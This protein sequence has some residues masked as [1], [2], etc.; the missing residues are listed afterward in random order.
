VGD[1]FFLKLAYRGDKRSIERELRSYRKIADAA[2]GE[3]V[4]ISRLHGIVQDEAGLVLGLL[5][6]YIDARAKNLA[7]AVR[8]NVP[9][10]LRQK[11]AV[12]VKSAVERLHTAGIIWGD[13][14]TENVLIDSDNDA[15][16]VDFDG[17]Y[18]EGWVD[19]ELAGTVAGD[20]QGMAKIMSALGV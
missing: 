7:C 17:G 5:L 13:V 8:P 6:T 9:I 4:R 1:V 10:S 16:V 3:E 14:K 19:K 18:T 12:Q 2:L 11:W 15:W 20:L